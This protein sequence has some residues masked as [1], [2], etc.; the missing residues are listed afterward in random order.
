MQKFLFIIFLISII[1]CKEDSQSPLL[2]IP[3]NGYETKE[4]ADI[5]SKNCAT[6][7]C[8]TGNNPVHA[9]S[10]DTYE[11]MKKGS[12][13]RGLDD[14]INHGHN[15]FEKISHGDEP[16]GGEAAIPFHPEE[17]LM[18]RLINGTV[19]EPL[20]SMPYLRQKISNN[21][22]ET[23]R[24]WILNG[25]KNN[26]GEVLY[27]SNQNSVYVANQGGDKISVIDPELK[28]VTGIIN[29][30]FIPNFIEAPHNIQIR[31]DYVYVSLIASGRFLKIN[32]ATNEV[33]SSVDNLVYPG[34]ILISQNGEIAYVSKSS[35]AVGSYQDIYK[36]NTLS[37]TLV[38]TILIPISGIPHAIAISND[39]LTL[40]VANLTRDRIYFIDTETKEIRQSI[41]LSNGT[42]S[43][44][45][46]MHIYLNPDGKELIVSCMNKDVVLIID[47]ET[48]TIK[49]SIPVASHPMQMALSSA[50][51]KLYVTS[52]HEPKITILNKNGGNWSVTGVIE[53]KAF[54]MLYGVDLSIDDKYLYVTSSNQIN[55]YKPRYKIQGMNRASNVCVIETQS[56]EVVKIIDVDSYATGITAR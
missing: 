38:D 21:D 54:V 1:G 3:N 31:D 37:M 33:V 44:F 17:S 25:A 48:G 47:T 6:S 35:T 56:N 49:Q 26:S 40:F 22:I 29:L 27:K 43:E 41:T 11:L 5:I 42:T 19:D 53:H 32:R 36:I 20:Y 52:M 7:G 55:G 10:F 18:F 24:Q 12:I 14:S 9:L 46:P 28:L 15:S 51:N 13:G 16:Y 8:H 50:G 45:A 34:M 30:N 23:I 4:V 2:S 39:G